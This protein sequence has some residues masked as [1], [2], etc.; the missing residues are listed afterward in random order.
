M[1]ASDRRKWVQFAEKWGGPKA[2]DDGGVIELVGED[3]HVGAAHNRAALL[4]LS[5]CSF[6]FSLNPLLLQLPLF[7]RSPLLCS[8]AQPLAFAACLLCILSAL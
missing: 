7:L 8:V 4:S 2:V 3:L 6:P 1:H 5:F